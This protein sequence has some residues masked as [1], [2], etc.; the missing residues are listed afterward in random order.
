MPAITAGQVKELRQSTGVGMMDCKKALVENDGDMQKAILWLRER[1]MS[2]AAKKAG[3]AAAE[4]TVRF[5]ISTDKKKAVIVEVNCETDFAGKNKDFQNFVSKVSDLALNNNLTS[6]EALQ[7]AELEGAKV[8]DKLTELIAKVGE[9]MTIRRVQSIAVEQGVVVGYSHMGGKIGALVALAGEESEQA[10]TLGS[11]LAMHVAASNPRF[12]N[13]DQV[14][15]SELEQ[16]KDLAR[17]KLKEQG[18]PDDII[19]KALIGQINKFYG[20]VCFLD[21]PFVKEPKLSVTKWVKQSGVKS[22]PAGFIRFQLGE[23]VEV[24]EQNFADE[25]AALSK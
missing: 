20:E 12:Y 4:G 1:G 5:S 2:R 17:K 16:E 25:V 14:D 22:Q 13:R 9:N 6:V 10:T 18:K 21:Q 3:R 7:N 23:G 24:K 15:T 11:D 8:S 19:E